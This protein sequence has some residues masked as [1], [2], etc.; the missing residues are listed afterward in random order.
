MFKIKKT[1]INLGLK[2]LRLHVQ[3][4]IFDWIIVSQFYPPSFEWYRHSDG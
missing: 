2:T 1:Q 4:D 3:C